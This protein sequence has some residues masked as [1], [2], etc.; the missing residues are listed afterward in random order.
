[1]SVKAKSLDTPCSIFRLLT[2]AETQTVDQLAITKGIDGFELMQAAGAAVAEAIIARWSIRPITVLCGPGNNGGDGFIAA[3]VLR[4]AGWPVTLAL[5]GSSKG[6]KGDA[7][8]AAKIWND[9]IEPFSQKCL[10]NAEIVIDAIFGAGLSRPI[11]SDALNIIKAL[12]K[13][14]IPVCAIDVPSGIDGSTG[15]VL[16]RAAVADLTVTFFRKK[17]AHLLYPARRICGDVVLADIGIP[18][19][20]LHELPTKHDHKTWENNPQLWMAKYPWPRAENYK[21]QRG[22]VLVLGGESMT[23]ASRMTAMAAGRAGAGIITVAAP[24]KVW[25]IY[26]TSLLSAIVRSIDNVEDFN[27]L[28]LDVRRNVIAI[29]PGAGVNDNTKQY[30]LSALATKRAVVLDADALSVFADD[31]KQLFNAI[32]GQ[33]VLTPHTGEFN[34][35]F[36]FDGDKLDC[37]RS[38]ARQSN[39]VIVLKGADTVIAAPDGRA[40]IN[41]NA[42][43]Q[44]A[45]GGSGD[46]LTGFT[47]ALLAQGMP[48]FEAAAAAVWLHG[49]AATEFGL[50]LIAEDLPNTLPAVLQKLKASFEAAE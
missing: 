6:L 41:S 40:I 24:A 21:Y 28:L 15:K 8:K 1:M 44:L 3:S 20:L 37:A 43:P 16:G 13:S 36:D 26:A 47:A 23:G 19:S 34:R 45:T 14:L 32:R 17:P 39:A 5:L 48:P 29:G 25:S 38:A 49:E 2:N 30:V 35:L 42:P 27:E 7:A 9:T 22:E 4:T 33:C 31:P 50:G 12:K 11:S 10:Y 46:V 18:D